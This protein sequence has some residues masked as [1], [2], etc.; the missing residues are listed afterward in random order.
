MKNPFIKFSYTD[1]LSKVFPINANYLI[2]IF[3]IR[4]SVITNN[5]VITLFDFMRSC[6]KE[7]SIQINKMRVTWITIIPISKLNVSK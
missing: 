2:Y 5:S 1:Y 6:G 3:K 4:F 7:R